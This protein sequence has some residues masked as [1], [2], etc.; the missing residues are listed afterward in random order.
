MVSCLSAQQFGGISGTVYDKDFDVPLYAVQVQIVE[1]ADKIITDNDGNYTFG[2]LRP[3]TYTLIFKKEGFISQSVSNIVVL[4]GQITEINTSI[5][6]EYT[7]MEEFVVQ[8]LS[9][10]GGSEI[11]LLNI[12]MESESL[13]DSIGSDLM[14]QATASNAEDGLRLVPGATVEGGK[15]A[16]V[17]GLPDRYVNSQMNGIRLPTA[18]ADKRAVQLD[19]FPSALIES[20]QVSKT[21]TPDQQGD[22]SG[23]AVNIKLKG[24]PDEPLLKFE[25]KPEFNSQATLNDD[26]LVQGNVVGTKREQAGINYSGSVTAGGKYDLDNGLT[27]GA[28]GTFYYKK[29]YS[30]FENG[31][32]DIYVTTLRNNRYIM[33]PYYK[34]E[35]TSLYDVSEGVE[36][37]QWGF[38]GSLGAEIEDHSL[39]LIFMRTEVEENQ[40]TLMEDVRGNAYFAD[41]ENV[42]APFHRSQT[43]EHTTRIQS[44]IQL[45][46]NH[47]FSDFPEYEIGSYF[48][49]LSPEIDW[50]A[51]LSSAE[52][53][54]PD[55]SVF[56]T[57]WRP[58]QIIIPGILEFP[59]MYSGYDPS[60]TGNGFA[61]R[62]W[63]NI[64][65]DSKQFQINAKLPFEQWTENEGY[66]KFGFFRDKIEREYDQESMFYET[67]G[68]YEAPWE[69]YWSNVY[70]TE[71]HELMAYE[72]DV[73]YKGEQEITASYYMFDLPIFS[74]LNI[75][76]GVRYESTD[77]SIKN[78]PESVNARYLPPDG[79][80][81]TVFGPKAD[82]TYQQDDILPSI[83]MEF[84]PV[85]GVKL[86]GCY[87]ETVARQTFKELSPVMQ[88][89]Y[90]GSDVFVGNPQLEMSAL[91]NYDLRVDYEPYTG[92][93]L[94]AS[95]FY[96][97][98]KKP[99]EY[100]QRYQASLF[101]TTPINYPEGQLDGYE[102]EI[103]QN[104]GEL[105][106]DYEGLSIGANATLID[107][108]VT[109]TAQEQED[110]ASVLTPAKSR[111]ML[112]APEYLYNFNLTYE[113]Q[114]Y[115]TQF[116][117]FYTVRGD[118][119]V[120]GGVA[121]SNS[122]VPDIYEKK[123]GTLNLSIK[124]PLNERAT[125]SFQAKNLTNPDIEQVYRSK[126]IGDDVTKS[127]YKKGI[128]LSLSLAY[129][130]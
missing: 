104:I 54:Q 37:D 78:I 118:T 106:S 63:K 77:L 80:G 92:G 41:D 107:S 70:A 90:L 23:G 100:V 51:A 111:D 25:I 125:L 22:A 112:N 16:V 130:F 8:E 74:K 124:Q 10:D 76:G 7:E 119:L 109:L 128:D 79:G 99:I 4:A 117:L 113:H 129:Q 2:Q 98:V 94:S 127:I 65:E 15:Y 3:G 26:F 108:E 27:L 88:M 97:N 52:M 73:D 75:I 71:D 67:G 50:I 122:Y 47:T 115:G 103:R 34:D 43:V 66:F 82:V 30:Y 20:I 45:K 46:G 84:T 110:F 44:T 39:S 48:R 96:K 105:W 60:G 35:H 11:A 86:R 38:L 58:E 68:S 53:D 62:I 40:A 42:E 120:E 49:F 89:E 102:F 93:L 24:I 5:I 21:F 32:N 1:T 6:P 28:L 126:Y 95:W 31:Q 72:G 9:M 36:K 59:A 69:S 18:D 33:I 57:V 85:D 81:W 61:Q 19:Q 114:T 29:D 14:S 56:S 123:Y 87:S 13:M 121:L 55:K 116:G 101:Y 83:G 12:R 17:R 64:T 91:E